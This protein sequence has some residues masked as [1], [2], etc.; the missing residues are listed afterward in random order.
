MV[1]S[2]TSRAA[3]T[4][5]ATGGE[6]LRL[7]H[8]PVELVALEFDHVTAQLDL[9]L[10]APGSRPRRRSP[11][12]GVV[13]VVE[14]LDTAVDLGQQRLVAGAHPLGHV[15]RRRLGRQSVDAGQRQHHQV[16]TGL[17]GEGQ[18]LLVPGDQ[19]ELRIRGGRVRP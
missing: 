14:Q 5:A 13:A 12:L 10:E 6:T 18:I 2:S 15:R 4:S 19:A 1:V 3:R 17:G 8:H 7:H 16:P 11:R 9:G